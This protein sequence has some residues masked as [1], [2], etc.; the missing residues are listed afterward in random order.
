MKGSRTSQSW[1]LEA[2]TG[3][4]E[5]WGFKMTVFAPIGFVKFYPWVLF[6]FKFCLIGELKVVIPVQTTQVRPTNHKKHPRSC[7]V[8]NWLRVFIY[9]Y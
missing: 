5:K 8:I 9:V 2:T 3:R 6:D 4:R 1:L 7:L